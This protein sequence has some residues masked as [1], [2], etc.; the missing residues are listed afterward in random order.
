MKDFMNWDLFIFG[1]SLLGMVVCIFSGN[2]I[3]AAWAMV[4]ALGYA[5]LWPETSLK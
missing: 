5:R 3:A 4:A 2:Y 1:I